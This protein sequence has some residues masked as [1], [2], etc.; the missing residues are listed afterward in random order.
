MNKFDNFESFDLSSEMLNAIAERGYI[1]PTPIQS[2]IIPMIL[3]SDYDIIGQAHTGTGKTAAFGIPLIEKIKENN[4]ITQV[5]IITPTRELALQITDDLDFLKCEK[6]IKIVTLYGGQTLK[7]QLKNL[8]EGAHIIIGTPGRILDHLRKNS[9][10]LN[11]IEY[12]VLDEADEMLK[13]GFINDVKEVFNNTNENKRM[14]LFSATMP[15]SI[16]KLAK[17]HM[18]KCKYISVS[19]EE[20]I[21]KFTT[22]LYYELYETQKLEVLSRVI[23]IYDDFYGLIFCNT[24]SDTIEI[25]HKLGEKGY[26][27]D[28]IN[29]DL[30]QEQREHILKKFRNKSVN[31]LVATD[32]AAR[33]IDVIEL[34]HV[35]NYDLPQD[36]ES[37]IHRI[38][39][40]GRAGKKGTAITFITPNNVRKFETFK[41]LLNTQVIK[42]NVPSA[43]EIITSR[44][45]NFI[46]TIHKTANTGI[47]NDFL[48]LAK[49]LIQKHDPVEVI[50]AMLKDKFKDTLHENYY[51]DLNSLKHKVDKNKVR[52]FVAIGEYQGMTTEK[53]LEFLRL[54]SGIHDLKIFKSEI[55]SKF[56]FITVNKS[57]AKILIAK[58]ADK[59]KRNRAFIEI[60]TNSYTDE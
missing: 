44:K 37:Y 39:R 41:K 36:V 18:G 54:E 7:A 13:M 5:L 21:E 43:K 58:F 60:A 24:K 55:Y 10:N 46:S 2:Q 11:S 34:T 30:A 29:G 57:Q 20:L 14:F 33:G 23:D 32:I 38:G 19:E 1:K 9:I 45:Q 26:S 17:R 3:N 35:I 47:Y 15:S 48:P 42:Q 12:L 53:L 31:I 40:T 16:L 56:S 59:R 8:E 6:D 25:A 22:Q 27:A 51:V 28:A 4:K 49:E 50:A 52:L